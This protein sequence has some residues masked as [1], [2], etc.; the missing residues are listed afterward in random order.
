M[1]V[2]LH[3]YHHSSGSAWACLKP[4]E[5]GFSY[6]RRC[7]LYRSEANGDTASEIPSRRRAG[8]FF[9]DTGGRRSSVP[10]TGNSPP[11]ASVSET[12]QGSTHIASITLR[13]PRVST[14]SG[15][16]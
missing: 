12:K 1:T 16:I 2:P 9:S 14:C 6:E 7:A 8:D 3:H 4:A 13:C 5:D 10:R 15:R 11:F